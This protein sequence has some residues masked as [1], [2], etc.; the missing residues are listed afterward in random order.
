M[1]MNWPLLKLLY[2]NIHDKYRQKRRHALAFNRLVTEFLFR[3]AFSDDI[4]KS[5]AMYTFL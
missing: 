3:F 2:R 1:L 4:S 5:G